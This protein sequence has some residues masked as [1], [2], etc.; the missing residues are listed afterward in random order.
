MLV[1]A[2]GTVDARGAVGVGGLAGDVDDEEAR[3]R[4]VPV[5]VEPSPP[6]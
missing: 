6:D 2:V 5:S 3:A 1:C 4:I